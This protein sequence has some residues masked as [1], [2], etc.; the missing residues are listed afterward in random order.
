[1]KRF[2]RWLLAGAVWVL[3]MVL[4][5][6]VTGRAADKVP[7]P[8]KWEPEI[9]AFEQ[10][11][12]ES[13]PAK[14]GIVFVGSSSIRKWTT[15]AQDF[16]DL[17]VINRGFGGSEI[18]DSIAFADRIVFPYEPRLIV[19]YAGSNDIHA[20]KSPEQVAADFHT[21]AEKVHAR[22]PQAHLDYISNSPNPSRWAEVDRVKATNGLIQKFCGEHDYL[23]F[24][25]FFPL[26]LGEGG[27]PRPDIFVADRL[28]M[29]ATGY[30]LWTKNLR[31]YLDRFAGR[32]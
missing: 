20:G 11:D 13:P 21:F 7:P 3:T 32:K 9:A 5:C 24:V 26:M 18:A 16:P 1:M 31:P 27:L 8:E 28:H 22:L 12:K 15:L 4:W 14:G 23:T 19:M 2:P 29:N 6:G 10:K 17:P 30:A 25:N